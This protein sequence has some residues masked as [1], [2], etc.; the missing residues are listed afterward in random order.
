[1]CRFTDTVCMV[2]VHPK[3]RLLMC[4]FTDT[5]CMVTVHSKAR[6]LMCRFTD[7]VCMVTVH[8]EAARN[9]RCTGA[10]TMNRDYGRPGLNQSS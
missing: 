6:L 8:S 3:A 4:R 9:S 7:T 5:V 2:T 10:L 1:M